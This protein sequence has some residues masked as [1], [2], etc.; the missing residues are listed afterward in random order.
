MPSSG[1][2]RV[3]IKAKGKALRALNK[4]GKGKVKI[5]FSAEGAETVTKTTTVVLVKK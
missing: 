2:V 4:K 5:A 3:L 1:N